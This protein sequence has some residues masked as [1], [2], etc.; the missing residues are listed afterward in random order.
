MARKGI[1]KMLN[2]TT[3]HAVAW[4]GLAIGLIGTTPA[5]AADAG[6]AGM[7]KR[8]TGLATIERGGVSM[9]ATAGMQLRSGDRVVTGRPGGV[10]I[11]LS[12]DSIV[13]AGPDSR[14]VLAEVNFDGTTHEGNILVRL[15]KGALH[16][17][18]GLIGKQSPQNIRIET[19]TAVMGV[20]GTEFI[21]ETTGVAQ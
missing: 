17:V 11:V 8:V 2:Q 10:G 16:F 1:D 21:V 12:D 15:A 14:V 13:T 5:W 20:R 4:V 3:R 18:T 7:I 6:V 9:Q 19:P